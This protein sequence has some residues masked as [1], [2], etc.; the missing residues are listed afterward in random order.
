VIII[1]V[2]IT[3]INV[4]KLY[5]N[6]QIYLVLDVSAKVPQCSH[7]LTSLSDAGEVTVGPNLQLPPMK[8]CY[9]I[10]PRSSLLPSLAGAV[11]SITVVQKYTRIPYT[12]L[13]YSMYGNESIKEGATVTVP[14]WWPTAFLRKQLSS[15]WTIT[16]AIIPSSI[17]SVRWELPLN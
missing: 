9:C 6:A 7:G 8:G 10:D 13:V 3:I 11:E 12:V 16:K 4:P 2:M 5:H 1:N 17:L 15:L 14:S